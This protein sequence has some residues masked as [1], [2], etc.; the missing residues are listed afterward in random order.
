MMDVKNTGPGCAEDSKRDAIEFHKQI[1]VADCHCDTLLEVMNKGRTF[2]NYSEEGHVD[3]P[4]L[5]QGGVK[6]QFFAAFIESSFK[7]FNALTRSLELIDT[8]YREIDICGDGLVV[9]YNAKQIR[10]ILKDDK[11]VAVLGIEGGEALNGNLSVLHALYRL[12]VRFLGLTWN[13]RNQIADGVGEGQTCGG[14]TKFGQE[15]VR[16]MNDLSMII[17]LAHISEAGFWDVLAHSRDP[18]MVSHANCYTLRNHPRNLKD[19][20]ITALAKSGGILGL[21]FF[22]EFTGDNIEEFLDHLDYVAALAGTEVIALGSDFDGIEKTAEGLGDA[23]CYPA[24]TVKLFER[25]Y[26]EKEIKGIMGG[27]VLRLIEKV[28]V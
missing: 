8:F 6:L 4:R 27:N 21:S 15:V 5:R 17:D 1:I 19:D 28:L 22:P 16:E 26:T 2:Y 18:V 11:I 25:G 13:Q 10:K 14:L 3:L 20:Q 23:R 24:I 7:P 12:G 9:G